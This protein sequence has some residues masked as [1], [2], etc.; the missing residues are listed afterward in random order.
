MVNQGIQLAGYIMGL[1]SACGSLIT[2]VMPEWRKTDMQGQVI[3][4]QITKQ[5]IWWNCQYFSTGQ[6]HCDDF[7]RAILG[8]PGELQAARALMVLACLFGFVGYVLSQ[9]GLG[10]TTFMEENQSSK[11]KICITG[12]V[13]FALGAL[14]TGIAVSYYAAVVIQEFYASGGMSGVGLSSMGGANPMMANNRFVYGSA[15]FIGWASAGL[16]IMG[17]VIQGCGTS[18]DDDED[19]DY[20]GDYNNTGYN[21]AAFNNNKRMGGNQGGGTEYI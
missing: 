5:G 17:G 6:W 19:D 15:L 11:R 20:R 21:N 14:C 7:D 4:M 13:C 1:L 8:L 9:I 12:A 2:C 10:C 3:E 18:N 16:G